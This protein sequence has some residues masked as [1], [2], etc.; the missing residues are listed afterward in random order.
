MRTTCKCL[1]RIFLP[2]RCSLYLTLLRN[3]TFASPNPDSFN[4]E[5]REIFRL[6]LVSECLYNPQLN[7]QNIFFFSRLYLYVHPPP[8]TSNNHSL[9]SPYY[10]STIS[11]DAC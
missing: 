4:T 2:A 8:N 9:S 6:A 11:K 10:M 1:D 7:L 3:S 5:S